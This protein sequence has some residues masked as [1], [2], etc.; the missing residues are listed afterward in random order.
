MNHPIPRPLLW[1]D[2]SAAAVAGVGVLLLS[3]WLS[4]V[5]ALPRELLIAIAVVNLL[6][7]GYS[8][9]LARRVQPPR[10]LVDALVVANLGWAAV[11]MALAVK[12]AH[13]ATVWGLLHLV[14]EGLFVGGL[15]LAEW[16]WRQAVLG[17][18]GPRG[19]ALGQGRD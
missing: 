11:C 16:R 13:S 18:P 7:G 6:Y 15:A 10:V 17:G 2:C 1:L 12:F 8:F 14:G 9:T 5:Q 3:D 4:R 19:P